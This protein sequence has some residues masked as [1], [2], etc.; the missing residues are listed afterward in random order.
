MDIY[1]L[2]SARMIIQKGK[3]LYLFGVYIMLAVW[4]PSR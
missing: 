3:C 2:V 4:M 1:D